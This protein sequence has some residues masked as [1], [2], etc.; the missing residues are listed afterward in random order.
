MMI[1]VD[2]GPLYA[3]FNKRDQWNWWVGKTL[4]EYEPPLYTCESVISE[5]IFLLQRSSLEIRG[6]M[7]LIARGHLVVQPAFTSKNDQ[8][9]IQQI[10]TNYQN[11]PASFADACIV[12]MAE[13]HNS[14]QIM[15]FDSDFTIY[16][17]SGGEPLNL[18]SPF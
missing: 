4:G 9:R 15:T 2:T 7:E 16:R 13:V 8:N 14:T 1:L 12:R 6:L 11:L 17:K 3:F 10:L 18:I 5:T